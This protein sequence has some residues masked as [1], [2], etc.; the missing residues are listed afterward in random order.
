MPV[1]IFHLKVAAKANWGRMDEAVAAIEANA[2]GA[3]CRRTMYPYT[4]GGT[5][6][7]ATLPLWVQEG[8]R[9]KMLERLK[10]PAMRAR[11]RQGDRNQDRWMGEP[12]DGRD[13]RGHPDRV[14]A[15]RVDQSILGK[16][17]TR[18]PTERKPD[19]WDVISLLIDSGG[20]IGAL[21]HMMSEAGREDRSAVAARHDRHRF[22][23]A[24]TEGVLR[25]GLA[26]P[27]LVRHVPARARQVRARREAAVACRTAV[28]RM[29]GVPPSRSAFA[30]AADSR[31]YMADLVVFDPA[32]VT[33]NA[34]YERPH[35]YPTGIEH[36]IVNGVPVLDPKGLTGARPGRPLYG[37]GATAMTSAPR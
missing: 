27:A 30:T 25:A 34:T 3:A 33:D 15:A 29:T 16:R 36:V 19:P 26:A 32:T 12:A 23:G 31:R 8:G 7:A 5:G 22:V 28:H 2:A 13:L 14:G 21:Y 35:Q 11:A 24:A 18:L 9:D 6:L 1:V 10:D 20:R 17:I 37:P 4:A